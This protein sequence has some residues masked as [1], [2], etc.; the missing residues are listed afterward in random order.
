MFDVITIGSATRDVFVRTKEM[1]IIRGKEFATGEG[2]CFSLG[3]KVNLDELHF[4]VGGGAANTAVTFANQGFT[5]AALASVG[6]DIRGQEI[7][8]SLQENNISTDFLYFDP[9]ELTAY[10]IIISS[11]KGERTIF[12]YRGA[13]WHLV[14]QS[15]PWNTLKPRWFYINHI[16]D[17]SAL[18]LPRFIAHAKKNGIH[19]AFN[20]GRT[21]LEMKEK[22]I[23]LLDGV[24][25]FIV[26]QE[27]ASYF[28][29]IPYQK[30]DQIF[31]KLDRWVK[32][33]V[34]MTKGPKGVKI[35]DG[36]TRWSAGILTVKKVIDRTGAGDAFG[37][38]FISAL[39]KKPGDIEYAIQLASCNASGVLTEWGAENGLLKKGESIYK[40][41][42]LSIAKSKISSDIIGSLGRNEK[43]S[44]FISSS[45]PIIKN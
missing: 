22:V 40:Y 30:T 32:G 27:E 37:S 1:R 31:N 34:I 3:S 11:G 6:K 14:E 33:I 42:K 29:G 18:L 5:V 10:S 41:G 21:Q 12:R 20:P 16:G 39:I 7:A 15:I 2:L 24:D 4:A 36:K 28:T 35:S 17:K 43:A 9:H 25:V 19:V 23:P 26:N 45:P 38:G 44:P 8:R 13:V